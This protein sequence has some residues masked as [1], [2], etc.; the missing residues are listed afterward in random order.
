M[1]RPVPIGIL[2]VSP[3]ATD[4][5]TLDAVRQAQRAARLDPRLM[6]ASQSAGP[7]QEHDQ[8]RVDAVQIAPMTVYHE[9]G[10]AVPSMG[11]NPESI[12]AAVAKTLTRIDKGLGG[13]APRVV[14]DEIRGNTAPVA[15]EVFRQLPADQRGKVMAY[16][17]GG[18]KVQ[19]QGNPTFDAPHLWDAMRRA[20]AEAVLESYGSPT[21]DLDK[22]AQAVRDKV[23]FLARRGIVASPAV[24]MGD[25]YVNPDVRG[26]FDAVLNPERGTDRLAAWTAAVRRALPNA[27]I[28]EWVAGTMKQPIE[29]GRMEAFLKAAKKRRP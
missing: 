3:N 10:Q 20:K 5:D 15:A 21:L 12:D 26:D 25:R 17:V 6:Y 7:G 22:G 11:Y 18:P 4:P 8:E 28:S 27:P 16:I 13:G 14:L 2:H 23:Q 19:Y 24:G 29:P 1:A 9:Y